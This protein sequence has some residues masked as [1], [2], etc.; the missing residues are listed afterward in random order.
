[1]LDDASVVASPAAPSRLDELRELHE[2]LKKQNEADR[3]IL[4]LY[5]EGNSH[6]EIGEILGISESNVGTR[7]SR[8]KKSLRRQANNPP[9]G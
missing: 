4:L 7:M 6:R 3:A 5:L 2:L 1:M 9:S 8:I